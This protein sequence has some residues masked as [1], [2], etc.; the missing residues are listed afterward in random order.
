VSFLFTW[1]GLP[2][3]GFWKSKCA[4]AMVQYG[5]RELEGFWPF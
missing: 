1:V 3:V 4:M 2:Q 5:K